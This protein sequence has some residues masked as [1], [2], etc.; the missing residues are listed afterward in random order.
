MLKL[1]RK[2]SYRDWC[3]AVCCIAFIVVQVW[4]NMT[5]PQYM[6][7]ITILVETPG[8]EMQEV[9]KAGGMMLLCALGSL[10]A[11]VITTLFASLI[12]CDFAATLRDDMFK[13]VEIRLPQSHW[14]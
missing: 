7:K 12:G 11:A 2:F 13:K 4:L 5:M 14:L 8:S 6:S 9:W 1:M 3:Y 10:V